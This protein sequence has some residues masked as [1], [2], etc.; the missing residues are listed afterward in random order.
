[1]GIFKLSLKYVLEKPVFSDYFP[2]AK[3]LREIFCN[4]LVRIRAIQ[5]AANKVFP[6]TAL[7]FFAR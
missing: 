3:R 7:L 6:Q 4:Y 1:M 2:H 5:I